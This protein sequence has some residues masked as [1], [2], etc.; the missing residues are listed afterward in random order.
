MLEKTFAQY[1]YEGWQR[2]AA[3]YDT[4]DLPTTR[5]AIAPILDSLGNLSGQQVLEIASGTGHLAAAALQQGAIVVGVD[6]APRMVALAQQQVPTGAEFLIGDAADLPFED[7][8]FDAAVC[9]FGL[10][11]FADPER[12]LCE[13]ARVLKPGGI[14][15]FTIW[16]SP[17]QGNEFFGLVAQVLEIHADR[18]I[19]LPPAPPSYALADPAMREAMLAQAG[20]GIIQVKTL[21]IAWPLQGRETLVEF[22]AK[23]SVR[24]RMLYERQT[25][26]VQARIREALLEAILP[27]LEAGKVEI[28]CP[29]VLVT[30]CAIAPVPKLNIT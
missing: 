16:Q 12:V 29:A 10:M 6:V 19:E 24:T 1:E 15:S 18:A 21:P 11:H 13:T 20:L 2:N 27:Y 25:T 8:R 14:C 9:S 23:G 26:E 7:A 17:D 5:Q 3:D 22:I 30:A 28:A 4:I